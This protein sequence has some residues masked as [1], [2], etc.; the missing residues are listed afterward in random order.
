VRCEPPGATSGTPCGGCGSMH[1]EQGADPKVHLRNCCLDDHYSLVPLWNAQNRN[2]WY[3]DG[4]WC[5]RQ[6]R[7]VEIDRRRVNNGAPSLRACKL[8]SIT[9]L[10]HRT[11]CLILQTSYHHDSRFIATSVIAV[12]CR[13]TFV[14]YLPL[15][16]S[17]SSLHNIPR[18][19]TRTAIA[20]D[21]LDLLRR[22]HVN[23]K[24]R[25]SCNR[26]WRRAPS[27]RHP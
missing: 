20:V 26:I 27:L 17:L 12:L 16:R 10:L 18:P 4:C 5:D 1:A 7:D 19:A 14:S 21:G 23:K 13:L 25:I 22:A 8:H 24:P 6:I 3:T 11:L 2:W 9:P 15:V